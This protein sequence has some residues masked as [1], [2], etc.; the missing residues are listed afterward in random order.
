MQHLPQTAVKLMYVMSHDPLRLWEYSDN[1]GLNIL[2][3]PAQRDRVREREGGGGG[4]E[5]REGE[6]E[7]G[8]REGRGRE[9]AQVEHLISRGFAR[10]TQV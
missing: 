7:G 6:G 1:R 3:T 5:E 2:I 8:K 4:G 10:G 9:R